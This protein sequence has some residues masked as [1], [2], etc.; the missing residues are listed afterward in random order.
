M[1]SL[2]MP[3]I[4]AA[5]LIGLASMLVSN[6]LGAAAGDQILYFPHLADGG[7]YSTTWQFTGLGAGTSLV[8]VELFAQD[9]SPLALATNLG[10]GSVFQFSLEPSASVFLQTL[11]TGNQA[12]VGWA[13]VSSTRTIGATETFKWMSGAGSLVC[14][15]AVPAAQAIGVATV[16][17]PDSRNT[18]IALVNTGP[19]DA[20]FDFRLL[21]RNGITLG[22]G[23]RTLSRSRQTALYVNQ[24]QGLENVSTVEGSLEVSATSLFSLVALQFE[25]QIFSTA[26]V[27]PGRD[28]FSLARSLLLERIQSLD[29]ELS[30]AINGF[31]GPTPEDRAPY[32][33]F[34]GLPNTGMTSLAPRGLYD[35]VLPISGGGAYFSFADLTHEYGHGS[36]LELQQ[37]FLSVGF[38]GYDFGFLTE[39]GNVPIE[40]VDAGHP[41]LQYLNSYV[42]P[43]NDAEIRA[44]QQRAGVGFASGTYSYRNRLVAR[45]DTTYGLRSIV[46][47][48][49][50]VL[51]VF[52]VVRFDSDGSVMLVWKKL[53]TFPVPQYF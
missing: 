6:P 25:G 5:I 24:I 31:L 33:T 37:G 21:D 40:G 2:K 16:M 14:Q 4:S 52:R 51:V 38:A 13:K 36:D 8:S 18:A 1:K 34:L 11:G 22:T 43:T 47:G 27:L 29:G 45:L 46:Y 19:A 35:Q 48:D 10:I 42:P 41:A 9:G 39:L 23:S 49:S 50:D 28:S 12:I 15:A 3:A 44:E 17:V 30:A 26:P 53:A 20:R 32:Q 7:G